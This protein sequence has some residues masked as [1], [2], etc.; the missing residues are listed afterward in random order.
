M[1]HAL[2]QRLGGDVDEL[3]LV[4]IVE[5]LVGQGLANRYAGDVLGEVLDRLE[6]LDVDGGHHVDPGV[7]D[8]LDV[9]VSLGMADARH[10]GVGELV[11]EH[12]LRMPREDR[13]EVHLL[14]ELPVVLDL[15]AGDDLEAADRLLGELAAVGLDVADD[16]VLALGATVVRLAE[17]REGLAAARR[18]PEKH[19][20][21]AAPDAAVAGPAPCW[22]RSCRSYV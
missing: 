13:V 22:R 20:Q 5:N 6:V 14:H 16:D 4:S 11:D 3:D 7:E 1:T 9:L 8:L 17:H 2:A 12:D 15:E 18:G 10:V 21:V 19:P